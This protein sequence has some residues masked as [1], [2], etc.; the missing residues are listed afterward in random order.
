MNNYLH[1][2]SI[3]KDFL[4]MSEEAFKE[5]HGNSPEEYYNTSVICND[6]L[7]KLVYTKDVFTSAY[8]AWV[9]CIGHEDAMVTLRELW[10]I[11]WGPEINGFVSADIEI[12]HVKTKYLIELS[13]GMIWRCS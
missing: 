7:I 1:S 4:S 5:K 10:D 11:E 12:R 2:E 8:Q 9:E 3:M 6:S 13:T